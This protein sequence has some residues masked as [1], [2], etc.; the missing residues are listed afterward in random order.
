MALPMIVDILAIQWLYNTPA[1]LNADNTV[2]GFNSNVGGWMGELF[3][4]I[5]GEQANADVYRGRPIT[6]AIQ[7]SGGVELIDFRKLTLDQYI[8]LGSYRASS[9]L[10]SKF[11]L[12]IVDGTQIEQ[13]RGG[14]DNDVLVGNGLDNTLWGSEGSDTLEGRG[15]FDTLLGEDGSDLLDGGGDPESETVTTM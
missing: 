14:S 3:A 13:A 9:I 1:N 15:G 4:A 6:L 12:H 11:N 5:T 10:G 2:Y 8:T 7:D